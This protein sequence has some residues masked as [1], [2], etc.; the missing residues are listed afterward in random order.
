MLLPFSVSVPFTDSVWIVLV[1]R[2]QSTQYLVLRVVLLSQMQSTQL[3]ADISVSISFTMPP[4]TVGCVACSRLTRLYMSGTDAL[5]QAILLGK[6]KMTW[7][8][9]TA[10]TDLSSEGFRNVMILRNREGWLQSGLRR[11]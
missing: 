3:P 11:S 6:E 4:S 5:I 2:T 1:A 8:D 9:A 7:Q 10:M